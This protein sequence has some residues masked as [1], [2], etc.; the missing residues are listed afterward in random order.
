MS[1]WNDKIIAEFR[2]NKGQGIGH[3]GD[4]LLLLTTR[5]AKTGRPHTTPLAFHRDGDR[6][7][8]IASKG[9]APDHPDWYHNVLAH[10]EADVEVGDET[11]H[12]KATPIPD[13]AER[14]RLY[15]QQAQ[16]M[17]GFREYELKTTRKIPAVVL[18]R[19][20]SA[21]KAA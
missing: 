4:H 21:R 5:G 11:F 6:Y 12:V 17:P 7:V 3:F 1:G 20:G 19:A 13:G 9:G 2:A 16:M 18:E 15:E 14:D 8:V 10:H